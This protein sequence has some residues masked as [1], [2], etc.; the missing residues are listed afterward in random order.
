MGLEFDGRVCDAVIAGF[1]VADL[2]NVFCRHVGLCDAEIGA[3]PLL[4]AALEK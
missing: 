2:G 3:D 1:D 4:A